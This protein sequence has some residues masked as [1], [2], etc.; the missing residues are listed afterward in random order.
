[1]DVL[2]MGEAMVDF[3][4]EGTGRPVREVERWQRCPGGAVANVAVGLARLSAQVAFMGVLG[5]DEFGD[6]LHE[7][8]VQE[9]VDVS[10]VRRTEEGKTGLAF[11]SVNSEGERSFAF[12]RTRAADLF[13]AET[14][15]DPDRIKGTRAVHLGTNALLFREAQRAALKLARAGRQAGALVACDPNVRPHLWPDPAQLKDLLSVLL[16]TCHVV[17]LAEDELGLVT[18]KTEPEAALQA[19]RRLG[20]EL[21]V[22]TLG[23]QGALFLWQERVVRVAAPPATLLDPTGAGDGFMAGLLFGLTRLYADVGAFRFAGVGELR[24]VVKF[25]C[26]VGAKVVEKLG[27]VNG[28]PSLAQVEREMPRILQDVRH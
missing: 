3:L 24:E 17:K 10:R 4:P 22:V 1:M 9:K 21:P 2:C 28:L 18:G 23:A 15:V 20:V 11:V 7:R 26:T 25:A 6:F 14:D 19:L 12:F 13:L 27:A 8:L 5:R 16:P